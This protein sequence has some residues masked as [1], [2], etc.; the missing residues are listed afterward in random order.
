MCI[1]PS[2]A[3]EIVLEPQQNS[4]LHNGSKRRCLGLEAV[5]TILV[6]HLRQSSSFITIKSKTRKE[7]DDG[8]SQIEQI[9]YDCMTSSKQKRPRALETAGKE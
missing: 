1:H 6:I 3:A 7:K 5:Y 4:R 8:Q 9:I 2:N